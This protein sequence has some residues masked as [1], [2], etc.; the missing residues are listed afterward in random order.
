MVSTSPELDTRPPD[1]LR[2]DAEAVAAA[3]A[4]LAAQVEQI[5]AL[6]QTFLHLVAATADGPLRVTL[7]TAAVAS[8]LGAR[9]AI[10]DTAAAT[11]RRDALAL[12]R[13]GTAGRSRAAFCREIGI[14]ARGLGQD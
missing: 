11:L 1:A 8:A 14:I 9:L 4:D 10:L 6:D 2:E 3:A 5:A 12:E 7:P 13:E